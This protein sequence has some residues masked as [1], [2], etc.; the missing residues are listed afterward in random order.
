MV[1]NIYP[2]ELEISPIYDYDINHIILNDKGFTVRPNH[3]NL[4]MFEIMDNI[5]EDKAQCLMDFTKLQNG[6][7]M[8]NNYDLRINC[9][10]KIFHK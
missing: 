10:Q 9:L 5:Y 6:M 7:K 2:N 1:K 8:I 3:N 4:T